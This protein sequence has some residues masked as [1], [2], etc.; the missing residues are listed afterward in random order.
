M[1]KGRSK[2][3]PGLNLQ[4]ALNQAQRLYDAEGETFVHLKRVAFNHWGYSEKSSGG[5]RTAAALSAFGLLLERGRGEHREIALSPLAVAITLDERPNSEELEKAIQKAA[6]QPELYGE[7]WE[8]SGGRMPSEVRIRDFCL[9]E[10]R[11]NPAGIEEF[12]ANFTATVQFAGL[13]QGPTL[14]ADEEGKSADSNDDARDMGSSRSGGTVSDPS[15]AMPKAKH[16]EGTEI[17]DFHIPLDAGEAILRLPK[18]LSKED[19]TLLTEAIGVQLRLFRKQLT[20]GEA[21]DLDVQAAMDS[22]HKDEVTKSHE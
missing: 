8:S 5:R 19:F 12:V 2:S 14:E 20:R 22:W 9:R 18:P 1:V 15:K 3:H 6:L 11:F 16:L 13:A 7:L 4:E 21:V 10:H 17:H